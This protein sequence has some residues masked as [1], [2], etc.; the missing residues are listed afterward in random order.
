MGSPDVRKVEFLDDQ[1]STSDSM[2]SGG[3]SARGELEAITA[4]TSM[5]SILADTDKAETSSQNAEAASKRADDK[6]GPD[7]VSEKESGVQPSAKVDD[8]DV[9]DLSEPEEERLIR[10]GR[11]LFDHEDKSLYER[12][13]K[14][15]KQV[16]QIVQYT[17]LM[18]DR[19]QALERE[20]RELK[21]I[22]EEEDKNKTDDSDEARAADRKVLPPLLIPEIHRAAWPEYAAAP[23]THAI[24]VLYGEPD[25]MMAHQSA[26]EIWKKRKLQNQ[27]TTQKIITPIAEKRPTRVR[28]QSRLLRIQIAELTGFPVYDN[29]K[30]VVAPFRPF[31]LCEDKIRAHTQMLIGNLK[32][33][34]AEADKQGCLVTNVDPISNSSGINVA[35]D[36]DDKSSV[37]VEEMKPTFSNSNVDE[38]T[39]ELEDVV[40]LPAATSENTSC[41]IPVAD[42]FDTRVLPGEEELNPQDIACLMYACNLSRKQASSKLANKNDYNSVKEELT[43]AAKEEEKLPW[44]KHLA[45]FEARLLVEEWKAVVGLLDN[46]LAPVIEMRKGLRSGKKREVDFDDLAYMFEPGQYV[47]ASEDKSKILRV[48][49]V[50]GGRRLLNDALNPDLEGHR[51]D[52]A[53]GKAVAAFKSLFQVT[54]KFSP[55]VVDCF[56][57]DF[58][59]TYFGPVQTT[60]HIKKFDDIQ[61]VESLP[62]FPINFLPDEHNL[63]STLMA[64]GKK[65]LELCS[66]DHVV[67]REYDGLSLDDPPEQIDSQIIVDFDMASRIAEPQQPKGS[68]WMPRLGLDGPTKIDERE[69]E[70]RNENC[71][72]LDCIS[73]KAPILN[74]QS[75]GQKRSKD[76]V[77]GTLLLNEPAITANNLGQ[78]DMM[79]LSNRIF[80]FVLRGR[81]WARLHIDNISPIKRDESN[82]ERLVLP[83]GY[84]RIVRALVETHFEKPDPN[85]PNEAQ[86]NVDLVRGK[87]KGL[88]ILLH[89]AP[90]VGKT[91]TAECVAE[92]TGRPLFAIT[93]GDIGETADEVEKN[94]DRCFQ[95]AHRW[96]FLRVLEYYAGILFLTTNRVG[97]FDEAFKSRIHMSLWYPTLSQKSTRKIWQM[98]LDRTKEKEKEL[99]LKVNGLKIMDFADSY[100]KEC[101][102]EDSGFWNAFQTALAL[103]QWQLKES[104]GEIR[105]VELNDKHFVKVSKASRSFDKYLRET[106]GGST[107]GERAL[108]LQERADHWNEDDTDDERKKESQ[109]R[110]AKKKERFAGMNVAGFG[111]SKKEKNKKSKKQESSTDSESEDFKPRK[112]KVLK[113]NH[114]SWKSHL[115]PDEHGE[116]DEDDTV[117]RRID[118]Q[119]WKPSQNVETYPTV[120]LVKEENTFVPYPHDLLTSYHGISS[121]QIGGPAVDTLR[122]LPIVPTGRN[123]ELLSI[124]TERL[125]PFMSSI[126]GKDPVLDFNQEWIPFM[127]QSPVIAYIGILTASYFDATARG[128]EH[129]KSVDVISTKVKLISGINEYLNDQNTA[130]SNEAISTVMSLAYNEWIYNHQDIAFAHMKG[131]REMIRLRG[132]LENIFPVTLRK[133]LTRT[134][135]QFACSLECGLTLDTKSKFSYDLI[136]IYPVIFDSPLLLSKVRFRDSAKE[137]AIS[138]EAA[139]ILD[140]MRFLTTSALSVLDNNISSE[141][142]TKFV[143]TAD[144]IYK[145]VGNT[146]PGGDHLYE[147]CRI[148]AVVY[149]ASM[150]HRK[151]LSRS[152]TP[153]LLGQFWTSMW[154]I[155][156]SRWKKTPGIFLWLI[157]VMTPFAQGRS[158]GRFLK[159]MISASIMAI[160]LEDWKVVMTQLQVFVALQKWLRDGTNSESRKKSVSQIPAKDRLRGEKP[161]DGSELANRI[162]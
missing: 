29:S 112:Q 138:P 129:E 22:K 98:N 52:S 102:E 126:D 114:A 54:E 130:M 146:S 71:D 77:L 91:S 89:G 64:R 66:L 85:T 42:S 153:A 10:Y 8:I 61:K 73:C 1:A 23:H 161:A 62:V 149:S 59:G 36:A 88:I 92:H 17:R 78:E 81:K 20:V 127:I 115:R 51:D 100:W 9:G 25:D 76:F 60:F 133:L 53:T 5:T 162:L 160:G 152:C 99:G 63:K 148:A 122:T 145:R 134:D 7:R 56:Q 33:L 142:A 154:K 43:E 46:E 155:S 24:D 113:I 70:P 135:Y 93:C 143:A 125:S 44:E 144:W 82:F 140:D 158:E 131:L 49:S 50:T 103:A 18:E 156:L 150:L 72:I 41:M 105:E 109:K 26:S 84:K 4:I 34:E 19:V 97:T 90:G 75:D 16:S 120:L 39:C 107:E 57:F 21:N 116:A 12:V 45:L 48:F 14:A 15:P 141:Q 137:L 117:S 87:G 110:K 65:F 74:D 69:I 38:T 32:K 123:V 86:Y 31:V 40:K 28:L 132:G 80:G 35:S 106:Y 159:S 139:A 55:L 27:L 119:L 147:T 95:M 101:V 157:L 6:D 121:I 108:E 94:L 136:D 2:T 111:G 79:L 67:H 68:G 30:E 96:V 37:R 3:S 118:Y 128:I 11:V 124:F 13:K 104:K 47:V 83:K 151:P 58:N